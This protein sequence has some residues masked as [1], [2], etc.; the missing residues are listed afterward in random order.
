MMGIDEATKELRRLLNMDPPDYLLGGTTMW[1]S[2][3][4][5]IKD[6]QLAPKTFTLNVD[7]MGQL[8]LPLSSNSIAGA[9]GWVLSSWAPFKD[10]TD[11]DET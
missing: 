4:F 11:K 9:E 3:M 1:A 7:D 8:T 5:T 10:G 2:D 6:F